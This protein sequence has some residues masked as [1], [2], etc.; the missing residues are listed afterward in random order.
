MTNNNDA[1]AFPQRVSTGVCSI[2]DNGKMEREFQTVGGMT[3]REWFAGMA[4][5]GMLSDYNNIENC[6]KTAEETAEENEG[7]NDLFNVITAFSIHFADTLLLKLAA[8][9]EKEEK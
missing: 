6:S 2:S 9:A 8:S 7:G 4:L 5:Q 1:P 3:K